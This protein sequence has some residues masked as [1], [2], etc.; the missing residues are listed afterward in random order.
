MENQIKEVQ[1]QIMWTKANDSRNYKKIQ[2]LQQL[3]DKL[4]TEQGL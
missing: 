4:I 2:A 1:D 3:L